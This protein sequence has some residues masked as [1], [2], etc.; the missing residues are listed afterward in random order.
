MLSSWREKHMKCSVPSSFS[1]ASLAFAAID[2]TI[3][4]YLAA[5]N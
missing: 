4:L 2:H 5:C 3:V 1:Y